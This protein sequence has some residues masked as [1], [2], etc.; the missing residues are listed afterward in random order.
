MIIISLISAIKYN[1][2][3]HNLGVPEF[4]SHWILKTLN[5]TLFMSIANAGV[6]LLV[7]FSLDNFFI[8]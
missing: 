6:C 7:F 5:I 4:V 8:L 2:L 1:C 3:I